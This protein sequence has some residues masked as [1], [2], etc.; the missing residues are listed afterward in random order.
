V[1]GQFLGEGFDGFLAG[2]PAGAVGGGADGH[3]IAHGAALVQEED[4]VDVVEVD[5]G[6]VG[7]VRHFEIPFRC[8]IVRR[9]WD[10]TLGLAAAKLPQP[11]NEG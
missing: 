6:R 5:L 11:K 3:G 10:W 1:L 2:F 4:A 8:R 7:C 9:V